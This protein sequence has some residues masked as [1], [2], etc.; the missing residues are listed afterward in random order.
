MSAATAQ[1]GREVDLPRERLASV[2]AGRIAMVLPVVLILLVF[3]AWPLLDI[4]LRSLDPQG[5]VSYTSPALDFSNY[6]DIV[7]DPALRTV[8][9]RTFLVSLW[10]TAI[11]FLI[12]FPT[13][14]L[15]SRL[16]RRTALVLMTAILLPFWVSILARLLA[17]VQILGREGIV[18]DV[19]ATLGLGGPH[20]LLFNTPSTIIGMTAYLLPYMI[21]IL[22][23]GMSGVDGT[24][25]TA[26]KTLGASGRQAFLRVYLPLIR[27][28]I[29]AAVLLVFVIGL[30]FFLTPAI[31]GG[32]RD[33]T[34]PIYIQSE[35]N[36]FQW[37]SACATGVVLLVVTLIGYA[38][39]VRVGGV[40][41]LTGADSRGA[42]GKG[43][44]AQEPLKLSPTTVA[45]WLVAGIA[46]LVLLVPLIV[47]IPSSFDTAQSLDWPPRGFTTA[48]YQEVLSDPEWTDAIAKSALV[49]VGTALLSTAM[50]LAAARYFVGLR[51][52][53]GLSLLQTAVYAPLVV[54]V[55]VLA[56]GIY[57]VQG[58]VGLLGTDIGLV[59]GHT[60]I[61]FPLA[62]A[63]L[64]VAMSN[65]DS[66]LETAAWTLGAS[67]RRAFWRVVVP[68]IA[69]SIVGALLLTF[70][71]SWDEV[72]IALFQTGF[73]K[74]L[75]V[76]IFSYLKSGI[77]PTVTAVATLLI[78]LVVV[79]VAALA[80]AS[81]IRARRRA[82]GEV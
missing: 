73:E 30:G 56:I 46:L 53:L 64:S 41:V 29:A 80:A 33:T 37:G 51:S 65:L 8:V 66:S 63:I 3:F 2:R 43:T 20:S 34:I 10:A 4:V 61:A 42:G 39:A 7:E 9:Y 62:F 17:F 24:L 31:L 82:H 5:E 48:W 54:P 76:V 71:T 78:V 74:T 22:Y 59:L 23:A 55:I 25:V 19:S 70:V 52:R 77:Q 57:D 26:A 69:P 68:N 15:M 72:A 14:Y 44:S 49:G 75:P 50:G 40:H 21:L 32:P 16:S 79:V 81:T 38:A 6:T 1:L 28:T 36:I 35:V 11:T 13:A 60:V 67:R 45:L 12:G 18:N 47:I 27:S 58:R